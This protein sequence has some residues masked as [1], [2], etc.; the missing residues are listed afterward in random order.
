MNDNLEIRVGK[1]IITVPKNINELVENQWILIS[2]F[3]RKGPCTDKTCQIVGS[4]E[5][6]FSEFV[7][8]NYIKADSDGNIKIA[9]DRRF[10][11]SLDRG[12]EKVRISV[13]HGKRLSIKG[14]FLTS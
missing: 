4:L 1:G 10:Q 14:F 5:V 13:G 11:L 2:I 8:E 3:S 9:F 12:R 7:P 6:S